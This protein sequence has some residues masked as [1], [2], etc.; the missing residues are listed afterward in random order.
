[1]SESVASN[2]CSLLE[3]SSSLVFLSSGALR[4]SDPVQ[5]GNG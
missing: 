2:V 1:M 4:I 3:N 5:A